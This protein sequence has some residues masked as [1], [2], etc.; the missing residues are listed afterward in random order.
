MEHLFPDPVQEVRITEEDV[1]SAVAEEVK[2]V[3]GKDIDPHQLRT[4]MLEREEAMS[5]G[6]SG[7]SSVRRMRATR[8]ETAGGA[9]REFEAHCR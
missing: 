8:E 7:R 6:G 1:A 5:R 3:G 2:A 9:T 4:S